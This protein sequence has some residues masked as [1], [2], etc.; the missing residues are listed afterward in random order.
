MYELTKGAKG[1]RVLFFSAHESEKDT[2][3]VT[4]VLKSAPRLRTKEIDVDFGEIAVKGRASQGSIIT[5][6]KVDKVVR[7]KSQLELL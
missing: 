3:S 2:L 6:H 7:R 5:R 1:T 4:V